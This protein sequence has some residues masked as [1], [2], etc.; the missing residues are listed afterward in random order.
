MKLFILIG[1]F[2][3]FSSFP[4]AEA[5]EDLLD[6]KKRL[7]FA[8]SKGF[9]TSADYYLRNHFL[10]KSEE[11]EMFL[12]FA[13]A[14][15]YKVFHK[16]KGLLPSLSEKFKPY[17]YKD[18]VVEAVFETLSKAYGFQFKKQ[19]FFYLR[20]YYKISRN[21]KTKGYLYIE[22]SESDF[23]EGEVDSLLDMPFWEAP[24][25]M[26][27][28]KDW[29]DYKDIPLSFSQVKTL[30]HEMGHVVSDLFKLNAS[31][32]VFSRGKKKEIN[33][34]LKEFHSEFLEEVLLREEVLS[35]FKHH[36]TGERMPKTFHKELIDFENNLTLYESFSDFNLS[37]MDFIIHSVS[38]DELDD[39]NV[40]SLSLLPE[41]R[42]SSLLLNYYKL[43]THSPDYFN[44]NRDWILKISTYFTRN[45]SYLLGYMLSIQILEAFKEK[46]FFESNLPSK[47]EEFLTKIDTSDPVLPLLSN[48]L[49]KEFSSKR[50]FF[51]EMMK[52]YKK[53]YFIQ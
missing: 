3:S 27:Q 15:M 44:Q 2:L 50:E 19:S 26:V 5:K 48:L 29:P 1:F 40:L 11:L 10:N 25:F 34:D 13:L 28:I 20:D 53:H 23:F 8:Q 37:V 42:D 14:P 41:K 36:E 33:F 38:L 21:G 52:S 51:L 31:S 22:K 35:L 32:Q 18:F 46:F 47:L 6:L 39:L 7:L 12:E 49:D 30:F 17:F 45:Y 16:N 4:S 9:E 24:L 43:L